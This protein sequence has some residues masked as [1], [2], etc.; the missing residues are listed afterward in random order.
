[1]VLP[2]AGSMCV[3]LHDIVQELSND[4]KTKAVVVQGLGG[5]NSLQEGSLHWNLN[6]TIALIANSL[7]LNSR[8]H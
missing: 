5:E 4:E 2:F 1:M 7:N 6:F 8:F 3:S